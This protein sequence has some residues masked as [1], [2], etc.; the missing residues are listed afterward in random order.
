MFSMYRKSQQSV[1]KKDGDSLLDS[2]SAYSEM[3]GEL[4][5]YKNAQHKRAMTATIDKE[6]LDDKLRREGL[7]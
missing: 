1:W 5:D 3:P 4:R 7:I 6:A 2:T